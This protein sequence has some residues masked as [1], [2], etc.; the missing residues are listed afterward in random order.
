MMETFSG[1]TQSFSF[2]LAAVIFLA[3]VVIDALYAFYTLSVTKRKPFSSATSGLVIHFLL[4]FG[5]INYVQNYLYVIPL[6][7]GSWVGT[8]L[9][10]KYEQNKMRSTI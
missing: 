8:F 10:V 1:F 3:Y 5:V 9:M 6:A 4:A 2:A 7:L